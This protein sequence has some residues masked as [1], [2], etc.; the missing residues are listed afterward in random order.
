MPG[1]S[2]PRACL[3]RWQ[4]EAGEPQEEGE[5]EWGSSALHSIYR[6]AL[7]T[8]NVMSGSPAGLGAA[9]GHRPCLLVLEQG[10]GLAG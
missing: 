9:W 2:P 4:W 10:W 6:D 1:R 3:P 8:D 5:E 7:D